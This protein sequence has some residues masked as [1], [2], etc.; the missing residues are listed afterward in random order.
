MNIEN[1][2]AFDTSYIVD[3]GIDVFI[4]ML[5]I[6]AFCTIIIGFTC[7]ISFVSKIFKNE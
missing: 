7:F 3:I 4:I 5:F 2:T 6:V 1:R